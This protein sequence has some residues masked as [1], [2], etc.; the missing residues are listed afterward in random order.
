MKILYICP[1][2]WC[3][4]KQRPQYIAEGLSK[5]NQVLVLYIHTFDKR[6]VSRRILPREKNLGVYPIYK[7]PL[8][9]KYDLGRKINDAIKGFIIKCAY[10][11]FKPEVV[12]TSSAEHIK[13]VNNM[14]NVVYDCMDDQ[15]SFEISENHKAEI[16][17]NEHKLIEKSNLVFVSSENLISKLVNRYKIG[18]S[19]KIHLVRNAFSGQIIPLE[20]G[21]NEINEIFEISY[22]GTIESWFDFDSI[23][24]SLDMIENLSFVLYGPVSREIKI[25]KHDRLVYKGIVEHDDLYNTIKNTDCFI[26]PFKVTELIKSVDPVKFYEYINFNKHIISVYY[27]EIEHY[28]EFVDFYT[29]KQDLVRVL[30]EVISRTGLKYSNRQRLEFLEKN[31]WEKRS[32][33]MNFLMKSGF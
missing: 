24:H 16:L 26:M 19:G 13:F 17:I 31:T 4:I 10:K 23:L 21:D 22:F 29:D 25:P 30:N 28:G 9:D 32:E 1:V 7:I 20:T 11:K 3:W 15:I 2:D 33:D 27:P 8:L 18:E 12:F 5:E 14:N 6:R